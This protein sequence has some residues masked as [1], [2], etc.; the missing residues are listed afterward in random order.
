MHLIKVCQGGSCRRN[1]GED[2]LAR[3]EKVL[4]VKAD[5]TTED[6]QFR[7]EKCGCLSHCENGPNVF[8]A[9]V[10]SPLAA[11]M[12]DGIVENNMLPHKL[13]AKLNALKSAT[14]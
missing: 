14:L 11:I 8:F 12:V 2:S 5:G 7:L 4:G 13:E 3:A 1:F 9:A 6:G 10:N